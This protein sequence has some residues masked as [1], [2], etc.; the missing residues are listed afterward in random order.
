M[1][2]KQITRQYRLEKWSQIICNRTESGLSV[3]A[4]C[5]REG[6]NQKSYYYW[7]RIIRISACQALTTSTNVSF[8][9]LEVAAQPLA[10]PSKITIHYGKLSMDV[11]D[12][13]SEALLKNT[14][15]IIQQVSPC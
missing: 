12:A 5:Q 3:R 1:E 13:T 14:F 8:A 15:R 7:L 9:P 4:F 11:Y 10:V 6:I 2:T